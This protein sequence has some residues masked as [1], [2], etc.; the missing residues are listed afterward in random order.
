MTPDEILR[1]LECGPHDIELAHRASVELRTL[2]TRAETA[3][4]RLA[5]AVAAEREACAKIAEQQQP[6]VYGYSAER[7]CRSIAAGIRA[8]GSTDA[9]KDAHP[10]AKF[11]SEVGVDPGLY[12][13][14]WKSGG[15]SLAAIGMLPNGDRWIAPTNWVRPC[16]MPSAGAWGEIDRLEAISAEAQNNDDGW[17]PIESAPKDGAWVLATDGAEI[18]RTHS[19]Y[20]HVW[21]S[22]GKGGYMPDPDRKDF[23]WL[24]SEFCRLVPWKPTHWRP[25]PPAPKTHEGASK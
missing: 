7:A 6:Y 17:L 8:R 1:R 20:G 16:E 12:R 24:A 15:S 9:Q 4:K 5:E 18:F 22:N 10:L 3:E 13:V 19:S 25:L 11:R 14:F 21:I 2:I 23:N